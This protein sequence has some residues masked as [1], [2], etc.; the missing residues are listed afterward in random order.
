MFL[1][2]LTNKEFNLPKILQNNK[3]LLFMYWLYN[4]K[5][6]WHSNDMW[7]IKDILTGEEFYFSNSK[8][9]AD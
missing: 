5:I 6:L 3:L 4:G 1:R 2:I 7:L 8:I 9:I